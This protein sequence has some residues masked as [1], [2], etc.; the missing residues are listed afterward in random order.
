M[1]ECKSHCYESKGE[2]IAALANRCITLQYL[3][4]C[5]AEC[6]QRCYLS[7]SPSSKLWIFRTCH[8][9]ILGKV[10]EESVTN[11]MY[12]EEIP[13]ECLNSLEQHLIARHIPF[14]KLLCLPHG[15]RR[16]CH[17]PCVSVPI[18]TMDVANILPKNECDD[19]IK[20]EMKIDI[21]RS[22]LVQVCPY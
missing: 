2:E 8:R 5:D 22:L 19:K 7:D 16:A 1:V 11:N 21:Q 17:G 13:A 14:M 4:V 10:P 12:L 18:N 15:C 9:K 3:H 20:I 6:E